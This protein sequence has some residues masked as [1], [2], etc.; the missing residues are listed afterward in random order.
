MAYIILEMEDVL[1]GL[2]TLNFRET[3]DKVSYKVLA[4]VNCSIKNDDVAR[5]ERKL[6]L[7]TSIWKPSALLEN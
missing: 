4:I 2:S 1:I 3:N 6:S 5:C 7:G